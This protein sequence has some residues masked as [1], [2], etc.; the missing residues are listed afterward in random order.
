MKGDIVLAYRLPAVLLFKTILVTVLVVLGTCIFSM[1]V[2]EPNIPWI[3]SHFT[4]TN[5]SSQFVHDR[6]LLIANRFDLD[7]E[8]SVPAFVSSLNLIVCAILLYS[9]SSTKRH[10]NDKQWKKWR[11]LAIIFLLLALDESVSFHEIVSDSLTI[12]LHLGYN[13]YGTV[14]LGIILGALVLLYFKSFIFELPKQTRMLFILSGLVF[15]GGAIAVE[16]IGGYIVK[17]TRDKT[18]NNLPVIVEESMEMLGIVLFLYALLN[19]M[20]AYSFKT[21]REKA[22]SDLN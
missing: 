22:Y 13:H 20:T 18:L 8:S 17:L 6:L 10:V 14:V 3:S 2:F 7:A 15:V 1:L 5:Q 12:V 21:E 11:I 4:M 19:Y 16:G 9:I